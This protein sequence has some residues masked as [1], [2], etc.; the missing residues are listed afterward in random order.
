MKS[1][2]LENQFKSA[3][4]N[5]EIEPSKMA[6]DRIDIMLS[7]SEKPKRNNNWIFIA[8]SFFGFILVSVVFLSQTKIAVDAEKISFDKKINNIEIDKKSNDVKVLDGVLVNNVSV[9]NI[10]KQSG[11]KQISKQSALPQNKA[12]AEKAAVQSAL[13]EKTIAIE[14]VIAKNIVEKDKNT[15]LAETNVA[16]NSLVNELLS[17]VA[18]TPVENNTIKV[19]SKDL[20]F[21]VDTELDLTFKER[22]FKSISRDFQEVK[23][24]IKNRNN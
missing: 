16:N 3:L 14:S 23:F 6:W 4:E 12:E 11:D 13:V 20:L 21:F 5:R 18:K 8:A 22:T 17:S 15:V 10:K 1:N 2:K 7:M 24:A 19:N 9:T